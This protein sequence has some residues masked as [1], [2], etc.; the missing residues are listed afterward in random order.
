VIEL[1]VV[2]VIL[3]VA[4]AAGPLTLAALLLIAAMSFDP[5]G[6]HIVKIDLLRS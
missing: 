5:S 1:V 2:C 4:V 6:T 3:L